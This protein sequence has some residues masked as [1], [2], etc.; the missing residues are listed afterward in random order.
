MAITEEPDGQRP[1]AELLDHDVTRTDGLV[2]RGRAECEQA[3]QE[4]E[5]DRRP[6]PGT[7]GHG[8]QDGHQAT[9][10]PRPQGQHLGR[11]DDQAVD[12]AEIAQRTDSTAET[13]RQDQYDHSTDGPRHDDR[14][15]PEQ[16]VADHVLQH[17][18]GQRRG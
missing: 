9:T 8:G 10:R 2:G 3:E 7:D 18:P 16:A 6:R 1:G 5:L 17:Q 14:A 4:A 13:A 11:A 15:D 12:H